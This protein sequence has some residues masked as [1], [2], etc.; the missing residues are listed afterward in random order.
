MVGI[1][2]LSSWNLPVTCDLVAALHQLP[3]KIRHVM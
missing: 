3:Q 1:G 2:L